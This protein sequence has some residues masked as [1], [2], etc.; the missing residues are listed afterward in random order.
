MFPALKKEGLH[1]DLELVSFGKIKEKNKLGSKILKKKQKE[2]LQVP[3]QMAK[4]TNFHRDT[5][6]AL[7]PQ[8]TDAVIFFSKQFYTTSQF[9]YIRHFLLN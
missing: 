5:F 9:G 7:Q 4:T 2:N 1:A 3:S 6:I 8:R